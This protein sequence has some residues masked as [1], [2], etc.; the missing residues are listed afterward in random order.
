MPISPALT[1]A[2]LPPDHPNR[3]ELAAEVHARPPEPLTAPRRISYVAVRIEADARDAELAHISALCHQHSVAPPP[4]GGTQWAAD[5]GLLRFKWERHGEFSSYTFFAPGLGAVPFAEPAALSLPAGWL[6]AVPGLTVCAAHAELA[7]AST[8]ADDQRHARPGSDDPGAA[9]TDRARHAAQD[10]LPSARQMAAAFGANVVMGAGIGEGAGLAL[11]DFMIHGDGFARFVLRNREMTSRQAGRMLQRLFEIEAYRMMALLALPVARGLWT[12]LQLI[13]RTLAELTARIARSDSSNPP[14]AGLAVSIPAATGH[15]DSVSAD[16]AL[17]Q[18]LMALAAEV[19]SA[20]AGS[21]ARFSASRAYHA[22]VTT[23][24]AELREQRIPGLQTIDEFMAR[25]L[26]PA[27][28]TC[29]TV[30]QRLHDLSERVAQASSLLSTRV[31]IARQ[32][33]N[34]ALLAATARRAKLQLRLQQTVEGLSVAAI[35]YYLVGL[36]GYSTKA[37]KAAGLGL[38]PD[39]VTGVAVPVLGLS[40]WWVLRRVRRRIAKDEQAEHSRRF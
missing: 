16:D 40:A 32:Q 36:V 31:D 21:Q 11:T 9:T 2:L 19:E 26:S 34:Q 30:S 7:E 24:I 27:M 37:L 20:L 3:V 1:G 6:A 8:V 14:A 17:L 12:R 15:I 4:Q 22:L 35:V 5:L 23:R 29:A 33:Q 10:S 39:L 18:Q 25:R 28:A 13:E 38:S